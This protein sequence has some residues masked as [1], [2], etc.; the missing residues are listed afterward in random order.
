M[1]HEATSKVICHR[2]AIWAE[3]PQAQFILMKVWC[4]LTHLNN[5]PVE[6]GTRVQFRF[7]S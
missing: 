2:D 1:L 3:T 7:R 4:L 6:D 5:L